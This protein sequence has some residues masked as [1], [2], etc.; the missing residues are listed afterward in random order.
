MLLTVIT[1][2]TTGALSRGLSVWL[3]RVRWGWARELAGQVGRSLRQLL[4]E[5]C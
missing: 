1:S 3:R 4:D 2:V 5:P